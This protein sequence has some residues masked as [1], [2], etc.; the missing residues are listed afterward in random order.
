MSG[1]DFY[2]R[3][4]RTPVGSRQKRSSRP[5][6]NLGSNEG[7]PIEVTHVA[8]EKPCG[9]LIFLYRFPPKKDYAPLYFVAPERVIPARLC[10]NLPSFFEGTS[11]EGIPSFQREGFTRLARPLQLLHGEGLSL[12][13]GN[14]YAH[15]SSG[16]TRCAGKLTDLLDDPVLL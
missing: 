4:H 12:R 9:K 13:A 1:Y 15:L 10:A 11:S 8:C 5:V 6:H 3:F 16:K 7:K 14:L 2:V